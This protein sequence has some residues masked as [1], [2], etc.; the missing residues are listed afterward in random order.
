M[1]ALVL[2]IP[3]SIGKIDDQQYLD[4]CKKNPDARIKRSSK[5]EIINM[6]PT[7]GE[8]GRRNFEL[9]MAF[10]HVLPEFELDLKEIE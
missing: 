2:D 3:D 10:G 5:G 4:L 1:I 9:G 7:G 6:P 8:T